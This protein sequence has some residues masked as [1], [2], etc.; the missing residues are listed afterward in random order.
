[1][2]FYASVSAVEVHDRASGLIQQYLKFKDYSHQCLASSLMIVLLYA[3]SRVTSVSEACARLRDAPS[4]ET[5]RQALLSWLPTRRALERRLNR[6]LAADLPKALRKG[7]QRLAIDLHE[8]PYHGQPQQERA[9]ICRSKPKCGTSHFHAYA[10]VYVIRKGHRFTLALTWVRQNDTMPEVLKRLLAEV[11]RIGV[12]VRFLLLDRG[13]YSVEV[14]RYLQA[15]RYPFLMPVKCAG[16]TPK[17]PRKLS[18]GLRRFFQQKRSGWGVHTWRNPAGKKATVKICVSCRNYRGRWKKHGRQPLV[19]AYW[20]FEPASCDWVRTTYRERFGIETSYRQANQ[21]RIRTSAR[22][23]LRRLLFIGIALILR[24][25]WVWFHLI[26]FGVRHG[27]GVT[28]HLAMLR[29]RALLLALERFAEM[30]FAV[31][32][33]DPSQLR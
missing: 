16:R 23:P 6:A 13:F 22:D 4:D 7:P 20:G 17:D 12:K 18:T 11:H 14:V 33:S 10:T 26:K 28:L 24:N 25:V 29:F 32:L 27:T 15:A 30:R 5:L 21:A 8:V 31:W 1:M 2:T 19:Y 9:E 3:A